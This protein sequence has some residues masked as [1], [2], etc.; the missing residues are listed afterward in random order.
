MRPLSA[1]SGA[2]PTF[3]RTAG[4]GTLVGIMRDY[5]MYLLARLA[6]LMG[7]IVVVWW[8]AGPGL[9]STIAAI[10]ISALI[11]YLALRPLRDSATGSLIAWQE[12]RRARS[13]KVKA[14]TVKKGSDE[15]L[16]DKELDRRDPDR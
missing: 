11:S 4:T 7:T 16:E 14:R 13:G 9:I 12:R 5:L 2:P 3:G 6:V 8:I 1:D 10:I 15:D